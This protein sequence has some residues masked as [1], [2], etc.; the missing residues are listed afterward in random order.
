MR[1]KHNAIRLKN[2]PQ[3]QTDSTIIFVLFINH[4]HV[5]L[6]HPS[7]GKDIIPGVQLAMDSRYFWRD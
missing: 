4:N 6:L 2:L 5:N 1:V 7:F 3:R